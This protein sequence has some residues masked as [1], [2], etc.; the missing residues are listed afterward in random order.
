LGIRGVLFDTGNTLTRPRGG[1]W[2]PRYDFEEVLLRYEPDAPVDRFEAAFAVG[3]A[4]L[5]ASASTAPRDDYHRAILGDLGFGDPSVELLRDLDRPLELPPIEPF[6]DVAAVLEELRDQAVRMAI[7]TDNWGTSQSVRRM[8]DLVGLEGYS[9]A[10]IVSEELGCNKPDPR[11]YHAASDV[12]G[13]LSAQCLFV[14]DDPSFVEAAVSLGFG[15]VT[16]CRHGVAR[17]PAGASITT[18]GQVLDFV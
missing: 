3:T 9:D 17:P 1:R 10:I 12:L 18:F 14:D 4:F 2:N 13:L 7:V 5:N 6:P 11:M 15:G 8:H 16:I